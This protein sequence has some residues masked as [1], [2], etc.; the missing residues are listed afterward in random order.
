MSE[1]VG[2]NSAILGDYTTKE[3]LF[4]YAFIETFSV[5]EAGKKAGC[6]YV[7]MMKKPHVKKAIADAM[8][9]RVERLQISA[10]WVLLELVKLYE[11]NLESIIKLKYDGKPCFDFRSAAPGLLACFQSLTISPGKFGTNIKV[12]IPDKLELLKMIGK[13]I[14]VK[15]FEDKVMDNNITII[16]DEQDKEA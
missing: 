14:N 16:Y 3:L 4:I 13:H 9:D 15:A 2:D 6:N 8:Q 11:A 5:S 12:Q 1:I 7:H 10:D